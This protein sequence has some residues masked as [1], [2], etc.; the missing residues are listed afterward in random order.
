MAGTLVHVPFLPG[1]HQEVDPAVAPPGALARIENARM[2][3]EGG[4][5]KRQGTAKVDV[6][7]GEVIPDEVSALGLYRNREVV[8]AGGH[9]FDRDAGSEGRWRKAGR[10]PRFLPRRAHFIHFDDTAAQLD[11]ASA[12]V[13]NGYCAVSFST[14]A[15]VMLIVLD[16]SGARVFS[17]RVT[18]RHMPRVIV[19]NG[20][21]LWSYCRAS[22]VSICFRTLSTDFTLSSESS[23]VAVKFSD[24]DRYDTI[25]DGAS[26]FLLTYRDQATQM[27]VERHAVTP[28]FYPQSD[29]HGITIA[30]SAILALQTHAVANSAIYVGWVDNANAGRRSVIDYGLTTSSEAQFNA[31]STISQMTVAPCSATSAWFVYR[32]DTTGQIRSV[33]VNSAGSA[34][35]TY[36]SAMEGMTLLSSPHLSD[37]TGYHVWLK[38]HVYNTSNAFLSKAVLCRFLPGSENILAVEMVPDERPGFPASTTR[39]MPLRPPAND[40]FD[41]G[42]TVEA[43]PW[44]FPA[45]VT[46]RTQSAKAGTAPVP[47]DPVATE[48]LMLYEYESNPPPAG[49]GLGTNGGQ[50]FPIAEAAGAGFVFGGGGQ[51]LVSQHALKDPA[52]TTEPAGFENG[53]IVAPELTAS[54]TNGAGLTNGG[55]YQGLALFEKIDSDGRRHRSYPSNLASATCNA[56]SAQITWSW[57]PMPLTEREMAEDGVS[58]SVHIYSTAANGSI[59]YRVTPDI[60]APFATTNSGATSISYVMSSEPNTSAEIIYTLGNVKPNQPAP[61]HRYG[62]VAMGRAWC[63]G[64]F[65]PQLVECSKFFV[66][67][68]PAT[69]TRDPAFRTAAPFPVTCGAEMD[70]TIYLL[71]P[72]GIAVFSPGVGPNNQ[73]SPAL[74]ATTVLSRTGCISPGSLLRVPGGIMFEGRR[75]MYM[76]AR[77]GSEPTYVGGPVGEEL[78]GNATNE[79]GGVIRDA[80]LVRSWR[81]RGLSESVACFAFE[82]EEDGERYVAAYDPETQRWVSVDSGRPAHRLASWPSE[83]GER[84]VTFPHM[85]DGTEGHA[86]IDAHCSDDYVS[87]NVNSEATRTRV[88]T[89]IETGELHPFGLL[90]WGQ[91]KEVALLCTVIDPEAVVTLQYRRNGSVTWETAKRQSLAGHSSGGTVG[92]FDDGAP[93][94]LPGDVAIL[95]WPIGAGRDTNAIRLRFSDARP[96]PLNGV[97]TPQP[98][99]VIY[100]GCTLLVSGDRGM[101][102]QGK[103]KRVA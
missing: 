32:N 26:D 29:G 15:D 1:I 67:N 76:L 58:T 57:Q 73:G 95:R 23:L 66:P 63:V 99:R 52:D 47:N 8:L 9:A 101:L 46:I 42:G 53:F 59:F 11:M 41:D 55:L 16:P 88:D 75:G 49:S 71:G 103:R 38:N 40:G 13:L 18:T 22:N 37:A 17:H 7:T 94:R 30:N 85:M 68:E 33:I 27:V 14:G 79:D 98:A 81:T 62:F 77:G 6:E 74:P 43:T 91:I 84:L 93:F 90:G 92:T 48:A 34:V 19:A 86:T 83:R 60:S 21:W 3:R 70:G 2:P 96:G 65:N 10:A 61:A 28:P 87:E 45:L 54:R 102:P 39:Q 97:G 31:G 64:L 50:P 5:I 78:S 4:I 100:H 12:A 72:D 36:T 25:R 89:S 56:A 20:Q 80:T 44:Y 82:S 69:F 24:A 51:E 35:S